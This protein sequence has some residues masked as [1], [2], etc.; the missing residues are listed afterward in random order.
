MVTAFLAFSLLFIL[1]RQFG[2]P[3]TV[4]NW[5]FAFP[6]AAT[7][8]FLASISSWCCQRLIVTE[9][10]IVSH[11]PLRTQRMA[12]DDIVRCTPSTLQ[13]TALSLFDKKKQNIFLEFG[14]FED[15]E[16]LRQ[17]VLTH[18]KARSLN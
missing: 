10:G 13:P 18:L 15:S 16:T 6:G 5:A 3:P 2:A 8:W 9:K 1:I 12:W 14:M 7:V 4:A 11:S 17:E